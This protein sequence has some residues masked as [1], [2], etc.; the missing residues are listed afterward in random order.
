MSEEKL[1]PES[2]AASVAH[3]DPAL[4]PTAIYNAEGKMATVNPNLFIN[5]AQLDEAFPST[6]KDQLVAKMEN[7]A[8]LVAQVRED[9][10]AKTN[11]RSFA[12]GKGFRNYG[13]MLAANQSMNNFPELAPNFV[14][15]DSFNDVVEDYL[16]LRDVGYT[17][18]ARIDCIITR[19]QLAAI[20]LFL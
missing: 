1:N 8:T 19:T 2:N 14:D 17:V 16:F 6:A 10:A 5:T 7:L 15:T 3:K 11:R 9:V 13:F 20:L 12:V 4:I 18:L